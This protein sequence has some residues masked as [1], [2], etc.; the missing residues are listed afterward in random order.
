MVER[1]GPET[2]QRRFILKALRLSARILAAAYIGFISLFA[3]DVLGQEGS[4]T[5]K[6]LG[7]FIHLL[8]SLALLIGLIVAWKRERAGGI[9][10][11]GLAVLF[12]A[13]FNTYRHPVN[14]LALSAPLFL[15]GG[16]FLVRAVLGGRQR[17]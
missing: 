12:T 14:F 7:L 11:I 15:I 4:W 8:P 1:S 17:P 10:F 13:R 9:V 16:L 3:M 5:D 6:A 2:P